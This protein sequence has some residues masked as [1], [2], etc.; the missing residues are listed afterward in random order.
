MVKVAI[1]VEE[2][3][4]EAKFKAEQSLWSVLKEFEAE[5]NV[6]LC[7]RANEQS[8]EY[9]MPVVQISGTLRVRYSL[10]FNLMV[11]RFD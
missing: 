4:L 11:Q 3:R 9:L 5:N 1:V 6:R 7:T 10:L 2:K 8:G